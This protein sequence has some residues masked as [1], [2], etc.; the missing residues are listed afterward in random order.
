MP[1][2][3]DTFLRGFSLFGRHPRW[4]LCDNGWS[5]LYL[6]WQI[7]LY[8]VS[9]MPVSAW[10]VNTMFGSQ[11][12]CAFISVYYSEVVSSSMRSIVSMLRKMLIMVGTFRVTFH[13]EH[14]TPWM[15]SL[16]GWFVKSLYFTRVVFFLILGGDSHSSAKLM[17]LVSLFPSQRQTKA[18]KRWVRAVATRAVIASSVGSFVLIEKKVWE[19]YY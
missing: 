8:R 10:C 6:H 12:W 19:K 17:R 2:S 7:Q 15:R 5:S 13:L 3:S 16:A 14:Y 1:H 18:S 4:Q 9:I 11:P